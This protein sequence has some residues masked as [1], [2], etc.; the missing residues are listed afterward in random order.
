MDSD[1]SLSL[2]DVTSLNVN[3]VNGG[4]QHNVVPTE[5][6]VKVDMRIAPTETYEVSNYSNPSKTGL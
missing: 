6:T 1:P 5:F 4:V 2:G 3:V